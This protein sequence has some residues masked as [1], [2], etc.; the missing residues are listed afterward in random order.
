MLLPHLGSATVQ[1]R[2]AMAN[3]AVDNLLA[4]LEDRRPP[5]PLNPQAREHRTPPGKRC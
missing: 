4:G 3:L 1:T 2:L 5:A